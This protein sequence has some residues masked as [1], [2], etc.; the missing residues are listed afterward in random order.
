MWM[1]LNEVLVPPLDYL[2]RARTGD[3]RDGTELF[4]EVVVERFIEGDDALLDQHQPRTGAGEE[5]QARVDVVLKLEIERSI[6]RGGVIW[7]IA[8]A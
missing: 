2:A 1:K 8:L 3:L 7:L 5:G 4:D 6:R